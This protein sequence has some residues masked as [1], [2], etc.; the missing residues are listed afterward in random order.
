MK[1][2]NLHQVDGVETLL[3][4]CGLVFSTKHNSKII[5]SIHFKKKKKQK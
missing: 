1:T 4:Y 5:N 2:K 3:F